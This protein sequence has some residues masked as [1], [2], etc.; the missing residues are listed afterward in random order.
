MKTLAYLFVLF[1]VATAAITGQTTTAASASNTN[2]LTLTGGLTDSLLLGAFGASSGSTSAAPITIKTDTAS[3]VSITIDASLNLFA[4]LNVAGGSGNAAF[5]SLATGLTSALGLSFSV[6]A[7]PATN[8]YITINTPTITASATSNIQ[9]GLLAASNDVS[10]SGQATVYGSVAY[11]IQ[12]GQYTYTIPVNTPSQMFMV[13]LDTSQS[14]S[15][16]SNAGTTSSTNSANA[17]S[18]AFNYNGKFIPVAYNS[19]FNL[20]YGQQYAYGRNILVTPQSS[21]AS[22]GSSAGQLAIN[23]V[24]QFSSSGSSASA[25]PSTTNGGYF[26][27]YYQI[28]G[29][30]NANNVLQWSADTSNSNALFI[31][32]T[33]AN[34]TSTTFA[35]ANSQAISWYKSSTAAGASAAASSWQRVDSYRGVTAQGRVSVYANVNSYSQWTVASG[36]ASTT[37]IA[38]M[39]VAILVL[40]CS[41]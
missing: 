11:T 5:T 26:N 23:Y 36:D 6:T 41:L 24:G 9:I 40:A 16:S 19:N 8:V 30:S 21:S 38:M 3:T 34:V 37:S 10:A 32:S 4:N 22:S 35:N 18:T 33:G 2:T 31:T 12:G 28:S 14:A 27:G 13:A 39:L 29:S 7:N 17:G 1:N 25:P 20:V 15:A